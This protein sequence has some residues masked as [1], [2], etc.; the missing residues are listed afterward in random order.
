MLPKKNQHTTS[1][2][3]D[4]RVQKPPVKVVAA[5]IVIVDFLLVVRLGV[6]ER[7]GDQLRQ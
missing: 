2:D 1:V 6:I 7:L 4:F 3:H 5:V